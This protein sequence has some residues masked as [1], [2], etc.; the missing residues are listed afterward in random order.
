MDESLMGQITR[1][2]LGIGGGSDTVLAVRELITAPSPITTRSHYICSTR[3][4]HRTRCFQFA[5][6]VSGFFL[7][8]MTFVIARESCAIAL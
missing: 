5:L 6:Q 4:T 1:V 7:F 3:L 8:T 2:V